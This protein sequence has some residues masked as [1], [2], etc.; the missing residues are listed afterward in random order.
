MAAGL[1]RRHQSHRSP[2]TWITDYVQE[3]TTDIRVVL[4]PT[5]S[6][7]TGAALDLISNSNPSLSSLG[8]DLLVDVVRYSD[9][10]ASASWIDGNSSDLF[11]W[12][13]R[14]V[15]ADLAQL[16]ARLET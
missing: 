9:L 3:I 2:D 5:G 15:L 16:A 12:V 6:N 8:T 14:P 10:R 7:Q 4:A 13:C 1:R 11:L